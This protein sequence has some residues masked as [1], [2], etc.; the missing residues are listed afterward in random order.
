MIR[1][2]QNVLKIHS[3]KVILIEWLW[4]PWYAS[5]TDCIVLYGDRIAGSQMPVQKGS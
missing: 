1:R 4:M 2:Y 3:K 5:R